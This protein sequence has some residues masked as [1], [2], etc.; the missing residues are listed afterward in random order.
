VGTTSPGRAGRDKSRCLRLVAPVGPP[1]GAAPIG[2]IG[3]REMASI[4]T[5][6][7]NIDADAATVVTPAATPIGRRLV[8]GNYDERQCKSARR[9]QQRYQLL[10]VDV[11]LKGAGL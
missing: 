3:V 8:W 10:H 6:G 2:I 9:N 11:L 1:I 4:A 7:S 5:A